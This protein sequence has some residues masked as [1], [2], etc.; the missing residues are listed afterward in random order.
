MIAGTLSEHACQGE[1]RPLPAPGTPPGPAVTWWPWCCRCLFP[2]A[3]QHPGDRG[4]RLCKIG[5]AVQ[6]KHS[7]GAG[8]PYQARSLE[9][10]TVGEGD[11][12]GGCP[13]DSA[14]EPVRA[15]C[16]PGHS[17]TRLREVMCTWTQLYLREQSVQNQ[18]PGEPDRGRR[19]ERKVEHDSGWAVHCREAG[20]TGPLGPL[21]W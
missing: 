13:A 16:N 17:T 9:H 7:E 21:T 3:P 10:R 2:R 11:K 14:A 18:G 15:A 4:D 12:A 20:A 6:A 1:Q 5:S 19:Q 8:R